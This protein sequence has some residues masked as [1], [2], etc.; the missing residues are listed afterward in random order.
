[1]SKNKTWHDGYTQD[2]IDKLKNNFIVNEGLVDEL[3]WMKEAFANMPVD[4]TR[5]RGSDTLLWVG[6]PSHAYY[7]D[8]SFELPKPESVAEEGYKIVSMEDRERYAYPN[9]DKVRYMKKSREENGWSSSVG[10]AG[11]SSKSVLGVYIEDILFAVPLDYT[12]AEDR[13]PEY[14]DLCRN[15]AM[16]V[17]WIEVINGLDISIVSR[18]EIEGVYVGLEF[19]SYKDLAKHYNHS[20]DLKTWNPCKVEL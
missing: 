14:R 18:W 19:I 4:I 2:Q 5:A 10:D 13:V 17:C 6:S 1:M 3:V 20:T 15:D 11:W 7:L 12:F 8:S 16:P 9:D